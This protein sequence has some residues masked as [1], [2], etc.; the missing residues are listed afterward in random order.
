MRGGEW[1]MMRAE[2]KMWLLAM[3]VLEIPLGFSA[4]KL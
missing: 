3:N 1:E 2:E 4:C